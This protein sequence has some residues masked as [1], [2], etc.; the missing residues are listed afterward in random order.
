MDMAQRRE[1]AAAARAVIDTARRMHE[2]LGDLR[3][4]L[5]PNDATRR[6]V[7]ALYCELTR[8]LEALD[9]Y[10]NHAE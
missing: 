5:E 4:P 9:E 2:Q 6:P 7:F 10:L 8:N 3:P 1:R